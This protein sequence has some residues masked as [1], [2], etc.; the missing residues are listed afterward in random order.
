VRVT[1]QQCMN[2]LWRFRFLLLLV[3][4][5]VT[6]LALGQ[7]A[8][9][10]VSNSLDMWY[11]RNDPA[12][13]Q[14][15]SFQEKFGSD[16]IVVVA[17][18]SEKSFDSDQGI[19][20]I[21]DLTDRLLYVDG[22]AAVTSLAT[23]PAPLRDARDRL[24]SEDGKTSALLVQM[25]ASPELEA[26]RHAIIVDIKEALLDYPLSARFAGYG[27]IYDSLNQASTEDSALLLL[28]AHLVMIVILA[29]FFR[30]IGPVIVTL[31]AVGV[32]TIW[33]MGL[34]SALGQQINMVSMAL[35]TLVLV[36]GIADCVHMLRSVARQ[37]KH[38]DRKI[39]VTKGMAAVMGPCLLTS[40]TTAV[41]F[42][43]L[44]FSDLPVVQNLG[45]FGAIGMLSA[46]IASSIVVVAS[47]TFSFAEPVISITVLDTAATRL[48]ALGNQRPRFVVAVFV[49]F[50]TISALGL[51]RIE[52]DT[53][54]I[55][56]LADDHPTRLDSDFIEEKIGAYAPIDYII[57]AD[58]VLATDVLDSLQN[59][60]RATG[61]IELLDWSWSILDALGVDRKVAP[62]TLAQGRI[63]AEVIR[64]RL[65]APDVAD[66]MIAGR[67]ELRVTF[68][69][70]MMSARSVRALSGEIEARAQFPGNVS[71]QAVGYASLY[72][73]IV[74]RLVTSQIVGFSVALGLIMLSIAIATRS[75]IRTLLAL[76]A[77]LVPVAATLGLMGWTGIPL[78][79]ATATIATVILGLIVD[80]TV[81]IL[82]PASQPGKDLT[83]TID[84]SVRRSGSS[85]LM[86]SLVLCGGFLVMGIA[87]VRSIAWFGLL[88][89]FAMATAILTDLTLLPALA[90]IARESGIEAPLEPNTTLQ[91]S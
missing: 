49:V 8:T 86:T 41:G 68:A 88:T 72:T 90:R 57:H 17:I 37:P 43:A 9:L 53:F 85:L 67:T 64:L 27:V 55:G 3:G 58:D 22:V 74:E 19:E 28:A 91:S 78:D 25:S 2:W 65:L 44:T 32:A 59:W 18:T 39:H 62:S 11:P 24:L 38:N 51:A 6:A 10:G 63:P 52:T 20:Q 76:P 71:V 48:C 82:R 23:V 33:T 73:K 77:N 5:G 35:P 75:R 42:M 40:L 79:V 61:E 80:D 34:Y 12:L 66:S 70:P 47:L 30:R 36:I 1:W 13:L 81:H 15:Q 14:Y 87:E 84:D 83:I 29:L 54:S 4:V 26:R 16:E 50:T 89:S 56:Y 45:L 31:L 60:Q 21:V 69:A 46:F 7:L